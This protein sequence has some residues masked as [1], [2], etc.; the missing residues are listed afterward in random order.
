MARLKGKKLEARLRSARSLLT[1]ASKKDFG[2][3]KMD[4]KNERFLSQDRKWALKYHYRADG[5][6]GSDGAVEIVSLAR[7]A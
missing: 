4:L 6:L 7:R 2:R 3:G 5:S 1:T